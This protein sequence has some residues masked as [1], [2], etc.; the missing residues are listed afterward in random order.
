MNIF[1]EAFENAFCKIKA[2]RI[3]TYIIF[4]LGV[5]FVAIMLHSKYSSSHF[6][7]IPFEAKVTSYKIETSKRGGIY[8]QYVYLDNNDCLIANGFTAIVLGQKM[9]LIDYIAVGDSIIW[10]SINEI[11]VYRN[12]TKPYKFTYN[13]NDFKIGE[14]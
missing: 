14:R 2:F 3:M 1:N 9:R 12:N 7:F 13:P 10:N 8:Y 4:G 11:H 5:I 6:E